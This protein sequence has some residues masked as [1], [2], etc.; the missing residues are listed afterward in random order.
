MMY[1][2]IFQS[3]KPSFLLLQ[4]ETYLHVTLCV[5]THESSAPFMLLL[6]QANIV[7]YGMPEDIRSADLSW[8][9]YIVLSNRL[10]TQ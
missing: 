1:I 6:C 3:G 10:S 7:D 8:C 2:S 5:H 4:C 9:M